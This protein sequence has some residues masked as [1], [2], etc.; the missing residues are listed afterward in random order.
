VS[1]TEF[2][3]AFRTHYIPA[4]VMRKKCQELM[5]LKQGGRFVHDY[6][7]LFN[8]LV[9]CAPDQVDMYDK[10]KDRFIIGFS[11]KLQERM[12][13][14]TGGSFP[15]IVSN[16]IMMDDAIYTHKEAKKRKV[17]SAPSSSA[18]PR[19]Q[20]VYHHGP[21]TRLASSSSIGTSSG[22]PAHLSASTSRQHPGLYLHHRQCCAY[23]RHRPLEP[24]LAAPVSIVVARATSLESTPHQRRMLLRAT[25][26]IHHVVCRRWPLQR[27]AV[28]S[29]PLWRTFPRVSKSS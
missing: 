26:L 12:A 22:L 2:H 16:V 1:W 25:S 10:K 11:T 24:P 8:H 23:L 29:T 14:N 13:L 6:S 20:T 21:P 9:Q 18:P 3:S 5:D 7:K 17:V 27:P 28:S 19:Y 15:K 4:G